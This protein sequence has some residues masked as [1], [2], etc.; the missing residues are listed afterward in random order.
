VAK[1]GQAEHLTL[2][3]YQN[4]DHDKFDWGDTARESFLVG[5]F[6]RE[7][8]IHAEGVEHARAQFGWDLCCSS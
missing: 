3:K 2:Q 5:L 8:E 7:G 6:P 1:L 4:A